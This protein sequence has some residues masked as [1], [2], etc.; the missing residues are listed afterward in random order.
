MID[1]IKGTITRKAPTFVVVQV[2]GIGI[3][4]HIP[5]STYEAISAEGGAVKLYTYLSMK[6]EELNLYGFSCLEERGLFEKLVSVQGI[7][8]KIALAV[9]SEMQVGEFERAVVEADIPSL[10]AIHG[11]GPKTAKRILFELKESI[12]ETQPRAQV[13]PLKR[14]A[15]SA[16]VSLGFKAPKARMLVEQAL[17]QKELHTVEELIKETLRLSHQ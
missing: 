12:K 10:T 6:N 7:G 11:I 5:L 8:A 1:F 17:K 9:L 13:S 15:V 3:S 16:L 4:L 14:E 2:G